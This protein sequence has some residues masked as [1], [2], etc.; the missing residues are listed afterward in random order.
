ML[1]ALWTGQPHRATRDIDFL[2]SGEESIPRFEGLFRELC[3]LKTV[4][5][6][7][8]LDPKTVRG[9]LIREDQIYGGVRVEL[10]ARLGAARVSIQVDVGFGDA[11]N[12]QV[13]TFPS[14]L[15]LPAPRL[16]AYPRESVIAEKFQAMVTLGMANSRMK[17]FY[18]VWMLSRSF[19]FDGLT[20]TKA[21]TATFKRRKTELPKEAPM[22]LT[23][24][25][26]TDIGK[27]IQWKAFINKS[28]ITNESISL[29]N[30]VADLRQFL[31][32]ITQS[33]MLNHHWLA[34]GPW[35]S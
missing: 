35:K 8:L 11:V 25:F 1:F 24:V 14:I 27:Q 16:R 4:D 30:V 18:D 20:L 33:E 6:G 23:T 21:I 31:L 10:L 5:D 19:D 13:V 22:A 32:P 7:L 2:G 3:A 29:E 12:A 34:G 17:D 9:S 15:D 28:G 26:S